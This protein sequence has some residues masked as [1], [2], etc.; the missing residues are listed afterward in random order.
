LLNKRQCA[1]TTVIVDPPRRGL[2]PE[3]CKAL[4]ASNA[5]RII[6]VSCDP[7]TLSRDL[8]SLIAAGYRMRDARMFDMF[9]RTAHFES[10][11]ELVKG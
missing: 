11:M 5:P 7:A 6:Y 1:G 8:Q 3:V 4:C 2:S 9:P 10:A